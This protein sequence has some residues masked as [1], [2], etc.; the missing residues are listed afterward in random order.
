MVV[1]IKREGRKIPK[2]WAD[3]LDICPKYI[4]DTLQQDDELM[5]K[6]YLETYKKSNRIKAKIKDRYID[7]F[8]IKLLNRKAITI[9]IMN[10]LILDY[11]ENNKKDEYQSIMDELDNLLIKPIER[12]PILIKEYKC[13]C[14]NE[15]FGF[16]FCKNYKGE[17][18]FI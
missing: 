15:G 12:K 13:N 9:S 6:Y 2:L 3:S 8:I 14:K 11:H 7:E 17:P 16:C 4:G 5:K 18:I 10:K 1:A